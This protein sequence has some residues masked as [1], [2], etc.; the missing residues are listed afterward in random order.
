[1]ELSTDGLTYQCAAWS[2]NKN[3][4][5]ETLPGKKYIKTSIPKNI[6]REL[7][8]AC[9]KEVHIIFN[10]EIY[11][12][13]DQGAMG[14]SSGQLLAKDFV[15]LLVEEVIPMLTTYLCNW[16][17]YVEDTHAY[18]NPENVDFILTKLKSYH[19]NTH[20]FFE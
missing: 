5:V 1:M 18:I 6:P 7:L 9:E 3:K 12:Q 13:N 11:I 15:T 20:F 19:Q 14:Y 17:R 2:N 8:H 10:D 16:K 4:F